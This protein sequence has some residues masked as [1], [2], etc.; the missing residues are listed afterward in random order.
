MTK[1]YDPAAWKAQKDDQMKQAQEAVLQIAENFHRD[2]SQIAEILAFQSRFHS[3]SIRNSMLIYASNPHA[4]FTASFAHF[5]SMGWSVQKGQKGTQILVPA[6]VTYIQDGE[7]WVQ[8]SKASKRLQAEY[9]EGKIPHRSALRFKIG[10]VFDISQTDCPPE[11]YPKIF[12]MGH[13]SEDH[14]AAYKGLVEWSA[15]KLKC[16]VSVKDIHSI[17]LRG[18]YSPLKNTITLSDKLNDTQLFSTCLHE[19]AHAIL[20]N[21]P[22]AMAKPTAQIEFEADALSVMLETHAGIE[23]TE[24]RKGHL[25]D[26]YREMVSALPD[27]AKVDEIL[28]PVAEIYKNMVGEIEAAITKYVNEQNVVVGENVPPV[29]EKTISQTVADEIISPE[30]ILE[31]MTYSKMESFVPAVMDGTYDTEIFESGVDEISI[32]RTA[33]R[34]TLARYDFIGDRICYN[35]RIEFAMDDELHTLRPLSYENTEQQTKIEVTDNAVRT[36]L[37]LYVHSELFPTMQGFVPCEA[38]ADGQRIDLYPDGSPIGERAAVS[39]LEME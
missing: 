38:K 21:S 15:D 34:L 33:D 36:Q 16:P 23:L 5:K 7:K 24:A 8:L 20:H 19:V 29:A 17:S 4:T 18:F 9:H 12:A 30:V 26:N 27:E 2:P 13:S 25:A 32:T 6:R 10:C 35:P 3:Y 37:D 39:I 28:Q 14:K 11:Q 1:N 22:D 31:R